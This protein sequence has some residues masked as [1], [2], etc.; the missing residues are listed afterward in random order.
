MSPF[1]RRGDIINFIKKNHQLSSLP[2]NSEVL[3]HLKNIENPDLVEVEEIK[4][5][6]MLNKY[7]IIVKANLFSTFNWKTVFEIF[8]PTGPWGGVSQQV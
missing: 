3:V 4:W 7:P 6:E 8:R 5:G 1:V 2:V